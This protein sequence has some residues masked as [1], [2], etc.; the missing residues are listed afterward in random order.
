MQSTNRRRRMPNAARK[1][2]RCIDQARLSAHMRTRRV[3]LG[4][5]NLRTACRGQR[6]R[7]RPVRQ[8]PVGPSSTY[9][10]LAFNPVCRSHS[11]G[12]ER[13]GPLQSQLR[14]A[15]QRNL[16]Q[17][18]SKSTPTTASTFQG[19][20]PPARALTTAGETIS[21]WGGAGSRR[22]QRLG[23]QRHISENRSQECDERG[24]HE[25]SHGADSPLQAISI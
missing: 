12:S 6:V 22:P 24:G 7:A 14:R 20:L 8:R 19:Y 1:P 10:R 23:L 13:R 15:A 11:N 5:P 17:L 21:L 16:A 4:G 25:E 18:S 3:R 2:A 9:P